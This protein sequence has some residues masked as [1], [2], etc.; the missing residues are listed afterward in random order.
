MTDALI[1]AGRPD[2]VMRTRVLCRTIVFL[3]IRCSIFALCNILILLIKTVRY[4]TF[5]CSIPY[6]TFK[7]FHCM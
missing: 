4:S 5:L 7:S 2:N 3:R 1:K 6:C